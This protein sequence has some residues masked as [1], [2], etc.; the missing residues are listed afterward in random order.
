MLNPAPE[1]TLQSLNDVEESELRLDEAT[2][3]FMQGE[4]RVDIFEASE[5]RYM[6]DYE[7]AIREVARHRIRNRHSHGVRGRARRVVRRFIELPT[8]G[9]TS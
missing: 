1:N 8:S 6:T 7:S 4:M 9:P 5:R 3:S 2:D